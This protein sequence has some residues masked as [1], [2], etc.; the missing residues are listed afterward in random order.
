MPA[1]IARSTVRAA[2]ARASFSRKTRTGRI[3]VLYF[4]YFHAD[5]GEGLDASHQTGWT[6]LIASLIDEWRHWRCG[7]IPL[8][9]LSEAKDLSLP[10]RNLRS[11][12]S[13]RMTGTGCSGW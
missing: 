10:C 11:F 7:F 12:A 13:L 1:A 4:E 6:G 8:V 3:F 9:I 2:R 5:T